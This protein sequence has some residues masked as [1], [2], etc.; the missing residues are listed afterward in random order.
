M[1][2]ALAAGMPLKSAMVAA[3][4]GQVDPALDRIVGRL[5]ERGVPVEY[6][7]RMRLDQLSSHGAHQG[8]VVRAKPFEYAELADVIRAAGD[9]DR[10]RRMLLTALMSAVFGRTCARSSTLTEFSPP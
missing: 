2:E 10:A 9:G 4:A 1:E 8:I 5:E 3:S 6:V 7:P